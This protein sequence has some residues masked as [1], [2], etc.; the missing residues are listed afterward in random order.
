MD[1]LKLVVETKGE[2]L[3]LT[4]FYK[5]VPVEIFRLSLR[6]VLLGFSA[7]IVPILIILHDLTRNP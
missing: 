3:L 7:L 4:L 2:F 6:K 1:N 5:N